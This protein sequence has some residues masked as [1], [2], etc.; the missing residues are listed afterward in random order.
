MYLAACGLAMPALAD[1]VYVTSTVSNCVATSICLS[2]INSDVNGDFLQI[3]TES[4]PGNFTTAI[5]LAQGKPTTAGA[6]YFSN[7]FSNTAAINWLDGFPPDGVQLSPTLGLT[8]GVYKVYHVF[9]SAAGNVSTNILLGVTNTAG[10]TLS[11]TNTDKFRSSFGLVSGGFNQWQLLGYL[12]NNIDTSTPTM[13]FFFE[14]GEVNAGQNNRL[15]VDTFLFVSDSC[16]DIGRV[17]LSG[18]PVVGD[19]NIVVTGVDASATSVKVYQYDNGTW[20]MVG[21]KTT[22]IVAGDNTV[23]VS[24]L[25][26]LGQLQAT[27][28]L[29]GQEGC[30]WG[31]PTGVVVGQRNPAVRM[32]LSLR[33]TT[34]NV[35]GLRGF[36]GAANIHFLGVT[37]RLGSAPG[38]PGK[39]IYPSNSVW[40]TVTFE[41]GPDYANPIDPSI[42]WNSGSGDPAG[43]VNVMTETYYAIDAIAFVIEDLTSTGPH[44]LYIDSIQNG[45][46]TF[47]TMEPAPAGSTDFGFRAPSFSGTTSGRLAGA[48]NST[49]VANNAA[50]E[51]TKSLRIQWAWNSTANDRWLRLTPNGVGDPVV[52]VSQP[53]TIRFLYVPNGGPM[54]T[55]PPAPAISA[56]QLNG[57]TV[58]NWV[59]GHRLQNSLNVTGTYANVSQ[60]LS[61]NAYTNITMGAFLGPW[62]N[63]APQDTGFFR[64]RD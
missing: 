30:L 36:F 37:N 64:L 56:N 50:Y 53:I 41:R 21:E 63:T 16:T 20:T 45:S 31:V 25:I 55:P 51:G 11:F 7:S 35:I 59:G 1:W 40:Q 19:T 48:P 4:P 34:N 13:T 39:V 26:K 60:V 14:G 61:P 9:S 3:Y 15:L 22:G 8:G 54:P 49:A 62:T 29:G 42:K 12:T 17:G 23:T 44:D 2:D 46:T 24:G 32:A 28:T 27:Q 47:Y 52:D 43:T 57:Q 5:S 6:R 38:Y 58:L 33:D 18:A 10:C